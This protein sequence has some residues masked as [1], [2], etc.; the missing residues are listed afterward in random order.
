MSTVDALISAQLKNTITNKETWGG[1]LYN[2][3]SYGAKGDGLTDDSTAFSEAIAACP[4]G[5]MV[6]FPT[7]T[8]KGKIVITKSVYLNFMG[9]TIIAPDGTDQIIKA[10]GT[11]GDIN[12]VLSNAV[13]R[14]DK[15]LTFTT[16][17]TDIVAGDLILLRD[18][19]TREGDGSTNVNQEVHMVDSVSGS[20]IILK[21]FVRLPKAVAASQNVYKITPIQKIAIENVTLKAQDGATG[22]HG[23]FIDMCREVTVKNVVMS[24]SVGGC[25]T[26]RRS[27]NCLLDGFHFHS[28]Q[29]TGSGQG[30]GASGVFGTNGIIFKN[31][32]CD[33]MRHAIDCGN[34][35]N[36]LVEDV[37][38]LETPS[39]GSGFTISHNGW[40]SDITFLRCK[41]Y[42]ENQYGFATSSQGKTSTPYDLIIY[43]INLIECEAHLV[44]GVNAIGIYFQTPTKNFT[45]RDCKIVL[46]KGD[47]A[48][49][50]TNYGMR[51]LAVDNSGVVENCQIRG[52]NRSI[53]ISHNSTRS[54]SDETEVIKFINC[55]IHNTAYGVW[56]TF[57][58]AVYVEDCIFDN[59]GTNIFYFDYTSTSEKMRYLTLKGIRLLRYTA[60]TLFNAYDTTNLPDANGVLGEIRDIYAN[61]TVKGNLSIT[62][63]KALILEEIL[64]NKN[65]EVIRMAAS[66]ALTMDA[67]PFPKGLVEG[68]RMTLLSVGNDITIPDG[69]NNLNDGSVSITI[70]P[71][72]WGVSYI[73]SVGTWI[74]I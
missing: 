25:V 3:K 22:N 21:D 59:I 5:G 43:N 70:G 20:S 37:V 42:G 63:G 48:S 68:Q 7:A 32:V 44:D 60:G 53:F 61:T 31:G 72:N 55:R 12:Y 6:V 4:E 9:S 23:I 14:G 49:V 2:V 13:S 52:F 69:A 45:I 73:W 57:V 36:V 62:A 26:F 64:L 56:A 54:Q 71:T 34:V 67:E 27:F 1:I 10:I 41:S 35:F 29:A 51:F 66:T 16:S 47:A 11:A 40:D 18:D 50:N 74:Q 8:Y 15:T 28:P 17:V 58:F 30:Y 19:S 39:G 38:S 33:G 24:N 46:G 65:G